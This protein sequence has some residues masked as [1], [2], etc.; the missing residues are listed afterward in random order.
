MEKR[1]GRKQIHEGKLKLKLGPKR[2]RGRVAP[3]DPFEDPV[4]ALQE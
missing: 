3:S 4:A 1:I 2:S